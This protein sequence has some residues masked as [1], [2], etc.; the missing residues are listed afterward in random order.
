M[1]IFLPLHASP[2]PPPPPTGGWGA[3]EM[4]TSRGG[5]MDSDKNK[6]E[7]ELWSVGLF[8]KQLFL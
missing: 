5:K 1:E 2:P 3:S 4:V 7:L 6:R 8:Q